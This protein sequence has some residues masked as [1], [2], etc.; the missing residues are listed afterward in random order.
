[1]KYIINEDWDIIFWALLMSILNISII[2]L[3]IMYKYGA[4]LPI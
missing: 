1:M 4:D 3:I 2:L